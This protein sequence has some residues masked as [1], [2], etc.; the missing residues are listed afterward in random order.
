MKALIILLSVA[1]ASILGMLY[2]MYKSRNGT[3]NLKETDWHFKFM[4]FF[5]DKDLS[6]DEIRNACPYYWSIVLTLIFSPSF[7]IGV[8]LYTVG[9]WILSKVPKRKPK[10]KKVK[11]PK[12]KEASKFS[13]IYSKSKEILEFVFAII[14]LSICLVAIVVSYVGIFVFSIK[15]GIIIGFITTFVIITTILHV[16]KPEL[17]QFH[18]SHY[19]NFIMSSIGILKIP[20]LLISVVLSA[21]FSKITNVYINNCPPIVWTK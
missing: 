20:Y 8:L 10:I 3:L 12:V 7:L 16:R 21:I 9:S 18:W 5:W 4:R 14:L 17:D 19:T 15:T 11:E 2:W 13:Y 6:T 1:V